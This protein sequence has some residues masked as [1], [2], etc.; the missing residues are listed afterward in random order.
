MAAVNFVTETNPLSV[1]GLRFMCMALYGCE[2]TPGAIRQTAQI[3][4]PGGSKIGSPK[5]HIYT[6]PWVPFNGNP[7]PRRSQEEPGG[8]R[9]RQQEPGGARR[10]WEEP[11]KARRSQEEPG[12]ARRS[13]GETGGGRRCQ[14]EPGGAWLAN[15]SSSLGPLGFFWLLLAPPGSS[16]QAKALR[17]S[18]G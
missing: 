13:H 1:C 10:T 2:F 4:C 16:G 14:E 15:L 3:R 6:R 5:V 7:G 12:A 9:K 17:P 8:A 11:G 18:F